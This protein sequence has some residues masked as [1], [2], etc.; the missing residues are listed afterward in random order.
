MA[1]KSPVNTFR[2][3]SGVDGDVGQIDEPR[4]ALTT[5]LGQHIHVYYN[6]QPRAGET[7]RVFARLTDY[8]FADEPPT[9]TPTCEVSAFSKNNE[10]T[11]LQRE[12]MQPHPNSDNIFFLDVKAPKAK[13][14]D[15][16]RV[17]ASVVPRDLEVLV[18]TPEGVADTL[19]NILALQLQADLPILNTLIPSIDSVDIQIQKDKLDIVGIVTK[20]LLQFK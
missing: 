3:S 4:A 7:V 19:A 17:A 12:V 18:P 20:G 1:T 15:V 11:L 16:I 10:F 2:T 14:I 9:F 6:K 13:D 8:S 5:G